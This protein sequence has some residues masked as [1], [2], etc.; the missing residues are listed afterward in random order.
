MH[1]YDL[2]HVR[3]RKKWPLE[4]VALR[5]QHQKVYRRDCEECETKDR[6]IDRIHLELEL[7]GALGE[8][9]LR[10]LLEIAER[11]EEWAGGDR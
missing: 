7:G 10:R 11:L 8:S 5:L 4:S 9:Q 6:K 1:R 2:A 3:D